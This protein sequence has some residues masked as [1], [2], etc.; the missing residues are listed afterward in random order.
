M[1][2]AVALYLILILLVAINVMQAFEW[3]IFWAAIPFVLIVLSVGGLYMWRS[4]RRVLL[5]SL[6]YVGMI[7]LTVVAITLAFPAYEIIFKG[8][9]SNWTA[10]LTQVFFSSIG[11]YVCGLWISATTWDQS[12]S[13]EWLAKFLGGPSLYLT[14]VS[15]LILCSA[16]LLAMEWLEGVAEWAAMITPRFLDREIIPPLTMFLFFWGVLLLLSKWWNTFYL[17]LS[18]SRW[19]SGVPINERSNLD[20]IRN[21][22]NDANKFEDQ[23]RFLWRRHDESYLLPRYI[24]FATPVL[25]FIGTVLGI[26]LAADGIRKI[27]GTDSGLSGLSN[28]LGSAIAPLGIAFDTTLIAL[29][30]SVALTLLLALV[31]RSE[32]RTLTVLERFMKERSRVH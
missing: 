20:R 24:S 13:L 19:E 18:I 10:N 31:Q 26:S 5:S 4:T 27:I 11:L 30:L 15:A 21:V 14:M 7:A 6:G 25:G 2:I 28:E 16:A 29:S 12:D 3:S 9:S 22:M 17:R 23:M 1:I 8:E 32:E